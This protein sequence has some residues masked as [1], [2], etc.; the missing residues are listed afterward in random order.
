MK[1][2][3]KCSRIFWIWIQSTGFGFR[4]VLVIFIFF[5]LF[6]VLLRHFDAFRFVLSLFF[7]PICSFRVD[8][9]HFEPIKPPKICFFPIFLII[10]INPTRQIEIFFRNRKSISGRFFGF[11]LRKSDLAW[12]VLALQAS[13]FPVL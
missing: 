11:H 7:E 8:F 3:L 10:G 13:I 2:T 9:A 1:V 12:S 6:R 5:P 4:R